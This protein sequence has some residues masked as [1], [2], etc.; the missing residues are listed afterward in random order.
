MEPNQTK[1]CQIKFQP[2]HSWSLSTSLRC[3][4]QILEQCKCS[5]SMRAIWIST[6]IHFIGLEC[7]L[8]FLKEKLKEEGQ[9]KGEDEIYRSWFK[10]YLSCE[11]SLESN[12]LFSKLFQNLQIRSCTEAIAE[13]VGSIMNQHLGSNRYCFLDLRCD[14][15]IINL[16]KNT[17]L[18]LWIYWEIQQASDSS[19]L[20]QGVGV[21]IQSRTTGDTYC[22]CEVVMFIWSS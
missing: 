8:N 16:L 3:I 5:Y 14:L 11:D 7:W 22:T 19:P 20:Q 15:V 17:T 9:V 13:T 18:W 1:P 6:W 4:F 10:K 21:G 2:R 12:I